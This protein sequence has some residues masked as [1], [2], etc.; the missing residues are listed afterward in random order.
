MLKSKSV[1]TPE[2]LSIEHSDALLDYLLLFFEI[3]GVRSPR[4]TMDF[5][6]E[7]MFYSETFDEEEPDLIKKH[8]LE[9][10]RIKRFIVDLKKRLDNYQRHVQGIEPKAFLNND[11]D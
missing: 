8:A 6:H 11:D 1:Q 4:T 3:G 10:L 2:E 5:L 7:Q 9:S